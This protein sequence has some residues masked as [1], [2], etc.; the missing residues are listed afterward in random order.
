MS[1]D[2]IIIGGGPA[3]VAAGVYAARKKIKTVLVSD[4]FG[5]QSLISDNIENWIGEKVIS[6][7]DLAKK[8]ET[9]L[10]SHEEIEIIEGDKV[11]KIGESN[12]IFISETEAGKKLE[13]KTILLACGSVRRKLGVPGEKEFEGKG[14]FYCSICDAP[15]MKDKIAVVVGGGNAGLEAAVDLLPY[16]SKIYLLHRRE[17]LKGDPVTQEMIVK[18]PKVEIILSAEIQ[19]IA[20]SNFV[21]KIT[22]K[23]TKTN[24]IK[25]LAVNGVFVEIGAVPNSEMV[26]DLVVLNEKGEVIVDHKT[27]GSSRLGIWAAGDVSDVLY[28]QNNVS[29]GDAIKAVLNIYDYLSKN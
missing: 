22:Y 2:L 4:S 26:K 29:A 1:Y 3:G 6:G 9:H 5:G 15:I 7:L 19:E 18:N 13:A 20:G 17:E 10:K 14:V 12:G 8:F 25:N 16:A 27:Q 21:E 24:E 28:K 11:L 23:D